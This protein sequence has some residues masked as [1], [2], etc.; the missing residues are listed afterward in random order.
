MCIRDRNCTI[1]CWLIATK[2][3]FSDCSRRNHKW[4]SFLGLHW[5]QIVKFNNHKWISFFGL[6]GIQIVMW[7]VLPLRFIMYG[8]QKRSY[9]NEIHLQFSYC[10]IWGQV[11]EGRWT[12]L[13][14]W[15]FN[16]DTLA[17]HSSFS[18][19]RDRF[20]DGTFNFEPLSQNRILFFSV[21]W[22]RHRPR[23]LRDVGSSPTYSDIFRVFSSIFK[24]VKI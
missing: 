19:M 4:I 16:F 1:A 20:G 8:K 13:H 15:F 9:E 5:T 17:S 14:S 11:D 21:E 23:N 6:R 22:W 18:A 3:S 10:Y 12:L 24:F 7:S 2:A